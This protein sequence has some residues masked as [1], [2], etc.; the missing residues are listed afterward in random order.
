MKEKAEEMESER[1]NE[2][3]REREEK[4]GDR[5]TSGKKEKVGGGVGGSIKPESGRGRWDNGLSE[6]KCNYSVDLN[7]ETIQKTQKYSAHLHAVSNV[8][9]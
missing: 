6:E 2:S 4:E 1:E 7:R 8:V 9:Q 5:K 3:N